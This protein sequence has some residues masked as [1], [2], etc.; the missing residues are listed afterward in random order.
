M[1]Y[2]YYRNCANGHK[3]TITEAVYNHAK[4]F[5]SQ[6][7]VVIQC[8]AHCSE[9]ITL[10]RVDKEELEVKKQENIKALWP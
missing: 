1:S 3:R 7:G 10:D 6:K 5:L 8:S 2:V 9:P 4:D